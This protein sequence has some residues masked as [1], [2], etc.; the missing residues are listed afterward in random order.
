MSELTH[1][2]H[3]I[4]LH[5]EAAYGT[6]SPFEHLDPL[7]ELI[8]TILSQSTTNVNSHRAFASLKQR[9][10]TW[11]QVRRARPETIATAI[12]SGGLA[13]VKS[14]VIKTIL[15]DIKTR[16]GALDLSFLNTIPAAEALAFLTSLKGVGPKTA[17]CVLLFACAQDVFPMDTHIFRILRRLGLLPEKCNDTQAHHLIE[18]H[19]PADKQLSLHINL[20]HHGRQICHP[21]KPQCNRCCLLEYCSYGQ[22]AE[23]DAPHRRNHR[24]Y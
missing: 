14:V 22:Q 15:N 12:Q 13:N 21:R 24:T 23:V 3:Q 5:L 6:P 1:Q 16:C 7:D 2:L 10:P 19:I 17:R 8:A 20:I 4:A 18:P 11:E 9:L